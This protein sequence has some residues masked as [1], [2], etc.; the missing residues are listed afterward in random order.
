MVCRRKENISSRWKDLS[1]YFLKVGPW[2]HVD[3][4][5]HYSHTYRPMLFMQCFCLARRRLPVNQLQRR[6]RTVGG[7]VELRITR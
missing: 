3:Q 6:V 4:V 5:R 7:A 2:H 1:R